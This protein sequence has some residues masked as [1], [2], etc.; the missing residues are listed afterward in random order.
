VRVAAL[1]DVPVH[2]LD[3]EV[4]DSAEAAKLLSLRTLTAGLRDAGAGI[5]LG[6]WGNGASSL[7][8]LGALD[9]DT[10]TLAR[11]LL[12]TV[13]RDSRANLVMTALMDLLHALDVQVVV[14]GVDTEAQLQWLTRWPQALLQGSL[15]SRP[16]AVLADVLTR[17]L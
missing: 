1:Y 7:A 6:K 5:S 11:D 3:I 16:Q 12:A 2:L 4:T 17:R 8:L 15:F 14:N 13:P 9:V 10:V